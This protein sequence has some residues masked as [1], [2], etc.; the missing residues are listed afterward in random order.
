MTSTDRSS[1][2]C[3]SRMHGMPALPEHAGPARA[4]AERARACAQGQGQGK[5]RAELS[6]ARSSTA[7]PADARFAGTGIAFAGAVVSGPLF[8][9]S[10][11][12]KQNGP[13]AFAVGPFK[14]NRVLARVLIQ[15]SCSKGVLERG[16]SPLCPKL[17]SKLGRQV[18][19]QNWLR[20]Q[21][22]NLRP[23]GYEPDELPDCSTP[24][25]KN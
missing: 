8:S 9:T 22:L 14:S 13:A 16:L 10:A 4:C 17:V 6:R 19:R 12:Q 20:G 11:G 24:R 25:L 3:V 7:K 2:A 21:D 1:R 23:S 18:R 15:G 5:A